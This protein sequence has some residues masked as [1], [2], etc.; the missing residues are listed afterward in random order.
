MRLNIKLLFLALLFNVA[1]LA[2]DYPEKP[3]KQEYSKV[4]LKTQT[5]LTKLAEKVYQTE[6]ENLIR[7]FK[8]LEEN[9]KKTQKNLIALEDYSNFPNEYLFTLV[10]SNSAL[11]R[12]SNDMEDVEEAK[13]LID[14]I[15]ED[16]KA[17]ANSINFGIT[18]DV[19][20]KIKV[21][22]ET[23]GGSGYSVFVKYSYD[24][25]IDKK[26]FLFNNK[27]NNSVRYFS[28]GYY[29]F[30]IEKEDFKSDSRLVKLET[31]DG[32]FEEKIV[33]EIN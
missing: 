12:L 29:I 16:Y 30:W 24:L 23:I 3:T 13:Q 21:T 20:S 26:R 19:N 17:K 27:T 1:L 22:V 11:I 8:N 6:D 32:D 31:L 33:F 15:S 18:T 25:D 2:Q 4:L 5:N 9:S 14:Y 7:S 28:P 10:D